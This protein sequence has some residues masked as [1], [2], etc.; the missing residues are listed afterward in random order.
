MQTWPA[1]APAARVALFGAIACLAYTGRNVLGPVE[2]FLGA[3]CAVQCS[4]LLPTVFYIAL[5]LRRKQM[6][7][8]QWLGLGGMLLL[9]TILMVIII[10]KAFSLRHGDGPQASPSFQ[11]G[12]G[13]VPARAGSV[14][15]DLSVSR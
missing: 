11:A 3:V 5:R 8:Q 6:P 9:G 15:I 7:W 13:A 1:A 12:M 4:L 10:A 14:R 2:S